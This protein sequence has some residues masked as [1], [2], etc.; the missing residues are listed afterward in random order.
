M[1]VTAPPSRH[2]ATVRC[3]IVAVTTAACLASV[4]VAVLAPSAASIPVVLTAWG[5]LRIVPAAC[6]FRVALLVVRVHRDRDR[7][8]LPL[9]PRGRRALAELR[10]QLD[11]LPE[12]RHPIGL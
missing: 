10:G 9:T 2:Q 11:D 1:S 12:I 7:R 5:L 6:R 3:S 4:G 8:Y